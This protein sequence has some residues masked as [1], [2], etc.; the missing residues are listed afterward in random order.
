MQIQLEQSIF[1]I[2]QNEKSVDE[3]RRE[4]KCLAD[5]YDLSYKKQVDVFYRTSLNKR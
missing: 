5:D 2:N 1:L 3:I 4:R